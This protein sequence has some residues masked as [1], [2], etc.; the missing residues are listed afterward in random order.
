MRVL[1]KLKDVISIS[2]VDTVKKDDGWTFGM[3][4]KRYAQIESRIL[5]IF[6]KSIV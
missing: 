3:D 1:K 6:I 4:S 2:Y 5:S